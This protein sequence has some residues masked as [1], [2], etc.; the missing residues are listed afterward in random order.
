MAQ[1]NISIRIDEDLKQDFDEL[2]NDLGLTMSTAIT[3][4]IK[5][6]VREQRIPFEIS[7]TS[8][9]MQAI[10]DME[11]DWYQRNMQNPE[12]ELDGLLTEF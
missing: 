2:C 11:D 7:R 6:V 9:S 4:F 10:Q 5:T 1:S 12:D 3:V 8:K